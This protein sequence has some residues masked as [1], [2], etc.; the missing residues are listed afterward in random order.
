VGGGRRA[1]AIEDPSDAERAGLFHFFEMTFELA[2][3]LL[4]DFPERKASG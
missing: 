4:K 2:G 1:S 3:K